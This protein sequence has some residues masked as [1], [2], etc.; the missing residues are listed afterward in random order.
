MSPNRWQQIK[1]LFNLA[2]QQ[3]ESEWEPFLKTKT[4]GDTELLSEVLSLLSHALPGTQ[5]FDDLQRSAA[6]SLL[7]LQ[8][9]PVQIGEMVG[10]YKII[11]ELGRGGMAVVFEAERKGKDFDQQVAIKV[12]KRGV[13][14][15]AVIERFKRER[16]LL[17]GLQHPAIARMYD[18]GSTQEGLPYFVMERC[19]GVS[20]DQYCEG[21]TQSEILPIMVNIC[22][23]VAY[24]HQRLIIH[25]DLKPANIL[26]DNQGQVKLLDFGIAQLGTEE[27]GL[28]QQGNRWMTPAYASPEQLREDLLT[29]GADV[30]QL[31]IIFLELLSGVRQFESTGKRSPEVAV[32]LPSS[33]KGD[34]RAILSKATDQDVHRR[35]ASAAQLGEDLSRYLRG[36]PV[37]AQVPS[38]GYRL[39]KLIGRNKVA[40]GAISIVL[41]SILAA[42]AISFHQAE[43]A[44]TERDKAE[45]T[46]AWLERMFQSSNPMEASLG[47]PNITVK[48]FLDQSLP[49]LAMELQDQPEVK[50]RIYESATYM[51]GGLAEYDSATAYL[52]K[53][54]ALYEEGDPGKL[55]IL[56]VQAQFSNHPE[57]LDSS[58]L[59]CLDY[60]E[61][62]PDPAISKAEIW[63][64]W[65][66]LLV[67][68]GKTA[69]GDSL[70]H[71]AIEAYEDDPK[72]DPESYLLAMMAKTISRRDQGYVEEADSLFSEIIELSKEVYPPT[73]PLVASIYNSWGV[74][75]RYQQQYDSARKYLYKALAIERA[76]LPETHDDILS[77][78]HNVALVMSESDSLGQAEVLYKEILQLK[79]AKYGF[80][81]YQYANTMQNLGLC[82]SKQNKYQ[83]S[84]DTLRRAHDI[85]LNVLGTSNPRV[86]F[87]LLTSTNVYYAQGEYQKSLETIL[88]AE[89]IL[90]PLLPASHPIMA[91][92]RLFTCRAWVGL[93]NCRA[94]KPVLTDLVEYYQQ[95]NISNGYNIDLVKEALA[96]CNF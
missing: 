30:Y 26:V 47:D 49:V 45:T 72:R 71:L 21:K 13:D 41:V 35:Y 7:D 64:R 14:T 75:A 78:L 65:G 23:A 15:A 56:L 19:D 24:A 51:Y 87:P 18:G 11:K 96:A 38:F 44:R 32:Q 60:L 91:D 25:R 77:T 62:Y 85:F 8:A 34:L 68:Q 31:G 90:A 59:S 83:E 22:E 55:R 42:S 46:L 5:T 50:A 70:L 94:A 79:G 61:A 12:M 74:N 43:I 88:R 10:E 67:T 89:S 86:A 53:T 58:F 52:D 9:L 20:V 4:G 1:D 84:V 95:P 57:K 73:H 66:H 6:G 33:L 28:T 3:P 17:A 80:Q 76:I 29:T 27:T 36:E 39:Q 16:R 82:L 40:F 48:A 2:I 92:V 63:R 69:Q 81:A 54:L 37:E 93:G